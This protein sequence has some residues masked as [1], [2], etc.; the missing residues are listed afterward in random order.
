MGR[1]TLVICG[2]GRTVWDD[3]G[4]IPDWDNCSSMAINDAIMYYP[5]RLDHAYSND[6]VVNGINDRMLLKWY[7]ARRPENK[8]K[9]TGTQLHSC[10]GEGVPGVR[11]WDIKGHGT[12]GLNAVYVGLGLGYEKIILCGIPLDNDGHFFDPPWKSTN[13]L[14][15]VASKRPGPDQVRFWTHARDTVFGGKVFSMSGRTRDLLGEP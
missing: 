1:E 4:R 3:L 11:H 2:G 9:D 15:E 13:F 6:C 8:Q 5:E 14:R 12:S 10:F 7:A